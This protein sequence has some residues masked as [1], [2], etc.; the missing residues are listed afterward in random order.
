MDVERSLAVTDT[1]AA[2]RPT[3]RSTFARLQHVH[4]HLDSMSS[5][6]GKF[7]RLNPA[8]PLIPSERRDAHPRRLSKLARLHSAFQGQRQ[9]VVNRARRE[10][11][12]LLS[13]LLSNRTHSSG[14]FLD[15]LRFAGV[16]LRRTALLCCFGFR[17]R[18]CCWRHAATGDARER[19]SWMRALTFDTGKPTALQKIRAAHIPSFVPVR[20]VEACRTGVRGAFFARTV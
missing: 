15:D 1:M 17:R 11:R 2:P 9:C 7:C 12:R 16:R 6:F 13:D 20:L 14:V 8:D 3:A 18:L 10:Y 5:S 19:S 4:S